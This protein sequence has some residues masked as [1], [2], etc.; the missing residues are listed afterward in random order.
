LLDRVRIQA[1]VSIDTSS[2]IFATGIAGSRADS[3]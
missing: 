3:G 2:G 1:R